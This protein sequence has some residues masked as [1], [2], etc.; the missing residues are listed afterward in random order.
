M[1]KTEK[2]ILFATEAHAGSLRK[3]K[4]RPYILHPLEAMMIVADLTD[5]DELLAAAVLHDTVE[6]TCTTV[7]EIE[8]DFG[9]R[10]AALVASESENKREDRPAEETWK[11]RKQETLDHMKGASY[12]VKLICL[13]DKLSN[14]REIY[15]DY[16]KLGNELWQRFNQKDKDMH[17]WYYSE[18][19]SILLTELG[20]VPAIREYAELLDKVFGWKGEA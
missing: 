3:G 7:T 4:T 18:I 11:T 13:G 15:R 14:M 16:M 9:P 1:N 2:A 12:D 6:D 10:V 20:D 8:R 17:C 5:D 19:Y